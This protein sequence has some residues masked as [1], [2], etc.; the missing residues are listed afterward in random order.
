MLAVLPGITSVASIRY[1]HE[2]ELLKGTDWEDRYLNEILPRT[3]ALELDLI[4]R[5]TLASDL[6]IIAKSVL[7]LFR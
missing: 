3:L 4:G 5:R 1:R 6:G 7:V 2:E